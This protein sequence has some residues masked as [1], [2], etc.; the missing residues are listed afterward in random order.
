MQAAFT[1]VA[2]ILASRAT[3]AAGIVL[4]L[5]W[6]PLIVVGALGGPDANPV[7]LGLLAMLST[8]VVLLLGCMGIVRGFLRWRAGPGRPPC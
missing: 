6:L 7:G 2:C 5:G 4:V 3:W 1:I 8:P